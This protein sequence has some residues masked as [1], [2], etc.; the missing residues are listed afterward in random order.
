MGLERKRLQLTPSQ[1]YELD[2]GGTICLLTKTYLLLNDKK[3]AKQELENYIKEKG[4]MIEDIKNIP[5]KVK[6]SAK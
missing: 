1:I 5:S 2:Y 3:N 4:P 6:D